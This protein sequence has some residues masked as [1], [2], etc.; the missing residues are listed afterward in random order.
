MKKNEEEAD[1]K[2][3]A[4]QYDEKSILIVLKSVLEKMVK[5]EEINE[6][7][8]ILEPTVKLLMYKY[9]TI[10]PGYFENDRKYIIALI[11]R[12][13]IDR[14]SEDILTLL[15]LVSH[16]IIEVS[17]HTFIPSGKFGYEKTNPIMVKSIG[18]SYDYLDQLE[19]D[20]GG[21]IEYK[22]NGSVKSGSEELENLMDWYTITNSRTN[23]IICDL[24]IYAYSHINSEEIPDGFRKKNENM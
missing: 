16:M 11:N 8:K 4:E 7:E 13:P 23:Q 9:R 1:V 22:R 2:P 15:S 20:N 21:P 14:Y 12:M 10:G 3:P 18:Q 6:L 17:T 24:F 19:C 5:G